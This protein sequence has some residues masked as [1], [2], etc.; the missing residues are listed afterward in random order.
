MSGYECEYGVVTQSD[1]IVV[2]NW[3]DVKSRNS[4]TP[5]IM[6]HDGKLS[7]SH[8]HAEIAEI[9]L[10]EKPGRERQEERIFFNPVGMGIQDIIVAYRIYKTAKERN[11]GQTLML[12]EQPLWV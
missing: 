6:Y 9:L 11:I 7:D 4:Q 3:E 5:A 12:W 1:K 2:D 10:G 8:I